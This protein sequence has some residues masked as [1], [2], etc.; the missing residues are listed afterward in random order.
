M[1]ISMRIAI[2]G[3]RTPLNAMDLD[4]A[5]ATYL[6]PFT[7]SQAQWFLG[8]A[9]GVDTSALVWLTANQNTGTL[10]VTVPVRLADQ[11]TVARDAVEHARAVGRLRNVHE[12]QHPEGLGEAA[13]NARNQWLVQQSEFVIGFPL[14][15]SDDGSGTWHTLK[16]ARELGRATL[17]VPTGTMIIGSLDKAGLRAGNR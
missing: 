17:V 15:A 8:G 13:F 10:T 1:K 5:F 11:P 16:Y 3:S 9:G 2:T 4:R 6:K 7:G 12:L 14:S